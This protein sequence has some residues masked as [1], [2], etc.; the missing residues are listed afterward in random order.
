MKYKDTIHFCYRTDRG[1]NC[2]ITIQMI[3]EI[4][5]ATENLIFFTK[6]HRFHYV[7]EI[8]LETV[9]FQLHFNFTSKESS[10]LLSGR[11]VPLFHSIAARQITHNSSSSMSRVRQ[12]FI[13]EQFTRINVNSSKNAKHSENCTTMT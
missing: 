9:N 7:N 10:P 2:N 4:L 6:Y 13:L 1:V 3:I 5:L 11:L 8:R 12:L